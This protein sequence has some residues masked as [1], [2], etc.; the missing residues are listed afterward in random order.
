MI[1]F[2]SL[3]KSTG[4]Y[5]ILSS[6]K[7]EKMLSHAYLLL[8]SDEKF[9]LE[10][11][12]ITAEIILC[13]NGEPCGECRVCNLIG[14]N[15]F[16]DLSIYPVK[17]GSVLTEDVTDL[18]ENSFIKPIESDKRVFIINNAQSMNP[19]AQNKLLKTLE[20]PPE[21]VHIILGAT[22]EYSL[23]P[24]VLS[25]VKRLEI[26]A[27]SF[28]KLFGALRDE[29]PDTD[30]LSYAIDSGDGTVGKAL[31]LYG[32]DNLSETIGVALAAL[33][34]MK[35]SKDVLEYSVKISSTVKDMNLFYSVTE[36]LLR[37]MLCIKEGRE[38]LV[39]NKR[40]AEALRN[41]EGYSSGAVIHALEKTCEAG[42][43]KKF[44]A[45][46]T[47]LLEWLLFQIL[48]GKYRWQKL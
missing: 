12:K 22:S 31:A 26:P 8:S 38:S 24:T 44:N 29:C 11:L 30:R 21:N 45:N 20:E 19:A 1:D 16:A 10:Y 37:D 43:R 28:E 32:D 18:I 7:R 42:K 25:R 36:L 35:S 14:Q 3:Y 9:L 6:E 2:L 46:A 40:I 33:T 23:L 47:M 48:E 15:N 4:A 5:A 13:A 34:E 17:G 27:F 41:A 39:R